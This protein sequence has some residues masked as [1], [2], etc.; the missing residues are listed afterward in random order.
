[1][2][3]LGSRK[4]ACISPVGHSCGPLTDMCKVETS[5]P[6]AEMPIDA[7]KIHTAS[8]TPVQVKKKPIDYFTYR[9]YFLGIPVEK[10]KATF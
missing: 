5:K 1:M 6:S 7:P 3:V 4:R 9:A 2:V 10:I 8:K